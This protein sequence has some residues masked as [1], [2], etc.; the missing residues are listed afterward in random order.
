MNVSLTA[1]NRDHCPRKLNILYILYTNTWKS[2]PRRELT[3][4]LPAGSTLSGAQ[5]QIHS[6]PRLALF[7]WA[8]AWNTMAHWKCFILFNISVLFS[9]LADEQV[10]ESASDMQLQH[11]KCMHIPS[12]YMYGC[13]NH[14]GLFQVTRL[15]S[16]LF[17]PTSVWDGT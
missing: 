3:P 6:T 8:C 16:P 1:L 9:R 4:V 2:L 12:N 11:C 14:S 7:L 10:T 13:A 15:H 5:T 17:N